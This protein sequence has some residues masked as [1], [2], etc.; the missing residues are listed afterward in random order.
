MCHL[1]KGLDQILSGRKWFEKGQ[2]LGWEFEAPLII[3]STQD[4]GERQ[5]R[6]RNRGNVPE[7][8]EADDRL[9]QSLSCIL[10]TARLSGSVG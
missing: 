5:H 8:T 6:S 2:S 7:L 10:R 1:R 9:F 3:E 4:A